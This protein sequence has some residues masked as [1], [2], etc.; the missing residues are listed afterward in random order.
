MP[1]RTAGQ[2][3][4]PGLYELRITGKTSPRKS[5]IPHREIL[6]ALQQ[7]SGMGYRGLIEI[8]HSEVRTVKTRTIRLLGRKISA[9]IFNTLLGFEVKASFKRIQ[10]PDMATARYLKIFTELGCRTIN[11][12]NNPPATA[13]LLPDLEVAQNRLA[14]AS[15]LSSPQ[16]MDLQ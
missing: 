14:P 1:K 9:H 10:C 6:K 12:P 3:N 2:L 11:L 7:A 8:Y 15:S 16:N 5:R 4:L 13:R